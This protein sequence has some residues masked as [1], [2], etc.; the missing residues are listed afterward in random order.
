LPRFSRAVWA[1]LA[2]QLL[3]ASNAV[4]GRLN[5]LY[6]GPRFLV[7][8]R[9]LGATAIFAAFSRRFGAQRP[10][11]RRDLALFALCGLLGV[12]LNQ[13]LYLSG[14]WYSSATDAS[15]VGTTIPVFTAGLA[16]AFGLE[17][18]R[19]AKIGGIALALV[20]ALYLARI[21]T[22]AF[23]RASV[24]DL[25]FVANCL[26]YSGY[27]VLSRHL[28]R[29]YNAATQIVWSF[30]F[31]AIGI[32]PFGLPGLRLLG[33][34]VHLPGWLFF[35]VAFTI[36]FSTVLAYY[37]GA[38][39]L[40]EV[41]SSTAAVYVYL[42]PLMAMALAFP[43]LG[44]RPSARTGIATVLIFAGVLLSTRVG[45]RAEAGPSPSG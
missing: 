5:V 18:L 2:V 32:L 17:R 21:D 40:A 24:G 1:L 25:L 8:V 4:V 42:Q 43:I 14:L 26:S 7:L 16:I 44:E 38:F 36:L 30:L 37:F 27:L 31:G 34:G 22:F 39:A 9:V 41:E 33:S 19:W 12:T 23:D 35:T 13:S 29:R 11:S 20:G 3:F 6:L 15:I 10:R 28:I 45:A